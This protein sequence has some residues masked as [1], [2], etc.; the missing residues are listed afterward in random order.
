MKAP[1][2]KRA[3][4]A[5]G[6]RVQNSASVVGHAFVFLPPAAVVWCFAIASFI[7]APLVVKQAEA[8][9]EDAA[10]AAGRIL[11]T[12]LALSHVFDG[13]ARHDRIVADD[14]VDALPPRPRAPIIIVPQ[15]DIRAP[16]LMPRHDVTPPAAKPKRKHHHAE[17]QPDASLPPPDRR[18]DT[19]MPAP[20]PH[21][22]DGSAP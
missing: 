21:R 5:S 18:P 16:L 9:L 1:V 15:P 10:W 20:V 4:L 13:A 11:S 2:F 14:T 17:R 3:Q 8:A 6:T 7:A 12:C 19:L 22:D